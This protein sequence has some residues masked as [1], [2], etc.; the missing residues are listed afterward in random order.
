MVYEIYNQKV[1][2]K[3]TIVERVKRLKKKL[4][5]LLKAKSIE[6]VTDNVIK[7]SNTLDER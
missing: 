6:V 3:G 7:Y 1:E 4:I 5:E 2:R